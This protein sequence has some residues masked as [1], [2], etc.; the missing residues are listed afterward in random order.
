MFGKR[1]DLTEKLV[2]ELSKTF[3]APKEFVREYLLVNYGSDIETDS[4][5]KWLGSLSPTQRLYATYAL[6][7]NQ[8]SRDVVAI[9]KPK[10]RTAVRRHLDIGCGYGGLLKAFASDVTTSVGIE[11]DTQLAKYSKLNTTDLD[12]T[13]INDSIENVG[14]SGLGKFDLITCTE[15]IEHVANPQNL[16]M[17]IGNL[18]EPDGLLFLRMPNGRAIDA[19]SSDGHFLLFGISLLSREEAKAFK[20]ATTGVE[21]SYMHM[22]EYYTYPVYEHW[23]TAAGIRGDLV[24]TDQDYLGLWKL[25]AEKCLALAQAYSEW[26]ENSEKI[27][28]FN[29]QQVVLRFAEYQKSFHAAYYQALTGG[30]TDN[31]DFVRDYIVDFWTI[32]GFRE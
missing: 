32:V 22:G 5:Q 29:R 19:V 16:A 26:L 7:T 21:D 18:L 11:I 6:S 9:V 4:V 30:R 13:I 2:A 24:E 31:A 10:L 23:L 17:A 15:V 8:R 20:Y 1:R 28:Y 12:V 25:V 14:I 3:E 27:P